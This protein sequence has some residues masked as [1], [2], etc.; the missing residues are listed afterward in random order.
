M[1]WGA[2][3][4]D[5]SLGNVSIDWNNRI[6]SGTGW[7]SQGTATRSG[8]IVNKGYFD[9]QTGLF[10]SGVFQNFNN[11]DR[12][13]WN[14]PQT[15]SKINSLSGFNF[16]CIGDSVADDLF[17]PL[18]SLYRSWLGGNGA[19]FNADT[20]LNYTLNNGAALTNDTGVWWQNI[21]SLPSGGYIDFY[22]I[23]DTYI[24]GDTFNVYYA[25]S[26]SGGNFKVQIFIN[27]QSL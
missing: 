14:L 15:F 13:L 6:L 7:Q 24:T 19:A 17:Y 21:L 10:T 16:G 22:S 1:A 20:I 23:A 3:Q 9:A 18:L 2:R 8:D 12:N 27:M 26:P 4:G 25:S 5:D 11:Y